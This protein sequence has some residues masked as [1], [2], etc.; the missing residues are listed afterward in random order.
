LTL[1]NF[2][3]NFAAGAMQI[4][5][6]NAWQAQLN[7]EWLNR[8]EAGLEASF[9]CYSGATE[10]MQTTFLLDHFMRTDAPQCL[11]GSLPDIAVSNNLLH[12]FP[13]RAIFILSLKA[14]IDL[15]LMGRAKMCCKAPT[16]FKWKKPLMSLDP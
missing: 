7:P 11:R 13:H 14:H 10:A 15:I 4:D 9:P 6:A 16:L 2:E 12:T 8:A 5:H 1:T 3:R